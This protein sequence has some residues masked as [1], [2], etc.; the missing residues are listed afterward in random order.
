[1]SGWDPFADEAARRA[2]LRRGAALVGA[3][4]VV[5]LAVRTHAP[6]LLDPAWLR[7]TVRGFGPYAPAVFVGIQTAQ[8]VLAPIPGQ[9][10]AVGGGY[11]FG[12]WAGLLYS[13]VG[14]TAGSSLVFALARRY[15]RPFVERAFEDDAV[16]RFDGFVDDH[17]IVGLFVVFLLPTFPDDA[18]CALA[19]LTTL[20][21]RTL[22]GLVIVGR[23][24]TFLLA[25]LAG[26]SLAA[27]RY[28]WV[29]LVGSAAVAL[30]VAV[31][32]ARDRLAGALPL[33]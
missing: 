24:P 28:E 13:M 7:A 15:G 33:D 6:F 32:A 18:V 2:V 3:L 9:T 21:L 11:L 12:T 30:T 4:V 1:M 25:T 23:L 29:L 27:A 26:D 20:R 5:A 8:V 10:L 14:V 17:G 16:D 31:Y 22:V 19:G